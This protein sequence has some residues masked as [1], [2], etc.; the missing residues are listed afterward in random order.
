M[1]GVIAASVAI[2]LTTATSLYTANKAK[3][4]QRD[5]QKQAEKDALAAEKQSRKAEAF[6]ETEGQGIGQLG[7]V[8]LEVDDEEEDLSINNLSI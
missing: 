3:Q 4:A 5:A 8:S 7:K 2:G 6:A 1:S